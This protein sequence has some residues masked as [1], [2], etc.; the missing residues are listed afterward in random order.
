GHDGAA[1]GDL[2]KRIHQESSFVSSAPE[3]FRAT[4]DYEAPDLGGT[5]TSLG[6][7]S[8][9]ECEPQL[10]AGAFERE[11]DVHAPQAGLRGGVV[12]VHHRALEL[13]AIT[14][15][16]LEVDLTGE[17]G[18]VG[19]QDHAVVTDMDESVVDGRLLPLPIG[20][21]DADDGVVER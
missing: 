15:G 2:A 19:E 5:P 11:T 1:R 4:D 9:F 13:V 21:A 10:G 12:A 14:P 20:L 7:R 18:Q 17:L 3:P 16:P 6:R 8:D